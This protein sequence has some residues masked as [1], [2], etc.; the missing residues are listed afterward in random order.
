MEIKKDDH[1]YKIGQIENLK[2]YTRSNYLKVE[3]Q[4]EQRQRLR[5]KLRNCENSIKS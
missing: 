5:E 2:P 1:I 3:K 4:R